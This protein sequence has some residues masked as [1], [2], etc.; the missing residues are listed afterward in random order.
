MFLSE[1]LLESTAQPD[2]QIATPGQ[3]DPRKF[4][5]LVDLIGEGSEVDMRVVERNL[6]N[7]AMIAW[8]DVD[9]TA[10]GVMVL[11]NPLAVYK[12]K[13]FDSAGVPDLR[14]QYQ[15]EL[16]YVYVRPQFRGTT[17]ISLGRLMFRNINKNTVFATC[18]AENRVVVVSLRHMGFKQLGRTYPSQRGDYQ[19]MLWGG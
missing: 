7:A 11:K 2:L 8:A 14:D 1:F 9:Q 12:R 3:I 10:V 4:G 18:R 6:Q 16:G 19:L 5:E 13:V 15:T 17:S